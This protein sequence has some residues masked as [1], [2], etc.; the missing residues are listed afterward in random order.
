MLNK[1]HKFKY[2]FVKYEDENGKRVKGNLDYYDG[3]VFKVFFFQGSRIAIEKLRH[4]VSDKF[5]V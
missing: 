1:E 4:R 5:Y 3:E 2:D